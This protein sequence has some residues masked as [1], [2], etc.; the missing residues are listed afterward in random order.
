MLSNI[1]ALAVLTSIPHLGPIKC[2]LLIEHFGSAIAAL[3]AKSADIAALPEIGPKIALGW[4]LWRQ[5]QEWKR[6]LDLV[7]QHQ[8]EIVPYTSPQYPKRLLELPDY[9][10]L[11]YIKGN[12]AAADQRAI[13]IVGTRQASIYGLEMAKKISQDLADAGFTIVSGLARG[14]DTA[15][16]YGALQPHKGRTLAVIGS[17]LANIYPAENLDL[18][19]EIAKRGA[20]ISEFSMKTPPDKKNFPQRNRIVSGTSIALLLIEAPLKSGA[21]ITV[22]RALMQK[23]KVFVLPGRAD[24]ESFRGNHKLIKDGAQLIEN[25]EDIIHSFN[26]LFGHYSI[27]VQKQKHFQMSAEEELFWKQLPN[28]E[29]TVEEIV[30]LTKLP[31]MR[32]NILLMSLLLK[33]AVKEFP[34]KIFKKVGV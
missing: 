27:P 29:V 7:E 10:V 8:V 18:S 11:L 22:E 1:E 16:H 26:D 28:Q 20:L 12:L 24:L 4:D 6:N 14:I 32:I 23:R 34:G 17:G 33:K 13:A 21:M 25:A 3:E 15:A 30:Q 19:K 2:R 5:D 31:V 9:P